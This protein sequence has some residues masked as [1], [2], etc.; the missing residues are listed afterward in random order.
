MNKKEQD[1]KTNIITVLLIIITALQAVSLF[2]NK[3]QNSGDVK[4]YLI[5]DNKITGRNI[6]M[7]DKN[8]EKLLNHSEIKGKK[9]VIHSLGLLCVR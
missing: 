1:L 8:A 4:C 7:D 3:T 2:D 9:V 5:N 6:G